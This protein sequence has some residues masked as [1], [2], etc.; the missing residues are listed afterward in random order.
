MF[1]PRRHPTLART[2]TWS[3]AMLDQ[4]RQHL[5][6][7]AATA[8][9]VSAVMISGSL[10]RLEGTIHSDCDLIVI[11][12]DTAV[13]DPRRCRAAMRAVREALAPLGLRLPKPA[14]I[15]A[16][17]ASH[18]QICDHRTLG[19]VADDQAIFGKRMQVLLDA[20][21]VYG[22]ERSATLVQALLERYAAGFLIYDQTKEWVA[23]LNDVIRYFRSY[24]VWRQFDLAPDPVDSW[25]MRNAKLRNSRVLAFA[26][27]ILLL[28]ECSKEKHDK[29]GWLREHLS[30][31]PLQRIDR[32]YALN[33][34]DNFAVLL[35]AYEV[36]IHT[37]NLPEAREQLIMTNPQSFA[38]IRTKEFPLYQMLHRNAD[39]LLR[40]LTRFVLARRNHWS[41]AF[42]EYLLF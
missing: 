13:D 1:D 11:G 6:P 15:Y 5:A 33:G 2:H 37:M 27:M 9:D 14:G 3:L 29:I 23:L 30:L 19:V 32:V 31:T 17:P 34:D 35:D 8:P 39:S 36:F 42:F 16:T 7:L 28:G 22:D 10:G 25:Y 4:I 24:C 20:R 40:E 38:E 12:G 21:A 41:T 26:A 18:A